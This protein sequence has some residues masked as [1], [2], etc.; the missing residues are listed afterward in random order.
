M[1]N[2]ILTLAFAATFL[3]AIPATGAAAPLARKLR[4]NYGLGI[5]GAWIDQGT[6]TARKPQNNQELDT[7]CNQ[8]QF[9]GYSACGAVCVMTG[10][11][12]ATAPALPAAARRVRRDTLHSMIIRTRKRGS[13][14][15]MATEI[16]EARGLWKRANFGPRDFWK[17]EA[18]ELWKCG[19][20]GARNFRKS[21]GAGIMEVNVECMQ[22]AV[23]GHV[24]T[25]E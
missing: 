20:F 14:R 13:G 18:R 15:G 9:C 4:V 7:T 10:S 5:S 23:S 17:F 8:M 21:W 3:L 2:S 19:D 11:R 22:N 25:A 6:E 24:W 1:K 16:M 12:L